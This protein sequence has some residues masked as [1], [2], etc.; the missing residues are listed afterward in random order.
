MLA[1]PRLLI[2]S[3]LAI[4][5]GLRFAIVQTFLSGFQALGVRL[6][7]TLKPLF[8][9]LPLRALL[10]LLLPLETFVAHLVIVGAEPDYHPHGKSLKKLHRIRHVAVGR[11]AV[12]RNDDSVP[13]TSRL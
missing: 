8:E 12:S 13:L 2:C 4:L 6:G 7:L 3:L 9:S 10:R 11:L 1:Q 5:L